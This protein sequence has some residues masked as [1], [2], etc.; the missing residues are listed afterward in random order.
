MNLIKQEIK[1][2]KA[3]VKPDEHYLKLLKAIESNRKMEFETFSNTG[4]ITPVEVF[5][6]ENPNSIIHSEC[7]DVV[8]YLGGFYIQMLKSGK[9]LYE[10]DVQPSTTVQI[11][12]KSLN[13]LEQQMWQ[14]NVQE[15]FLE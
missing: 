14:K 10:F 1:T 8:R 5:K 3:K 7:T 2:E 9:Y 12:H 6:N 13:I 15:K 4:R 11:E